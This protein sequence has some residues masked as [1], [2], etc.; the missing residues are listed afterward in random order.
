[1]KHY[2]IKNK[3]L[4]NRPIDIILDNFEEKINFSA[5][6]ANAAKCVPK[7]R[8]DAIGKLDSGFNFNINNLNKHI[9][10]LQM[11]IFCQT[12]INGHIHLFNKNVLFDFKDE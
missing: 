5:L 8:Y 2:L 4:I 3:T 11:D 7:S 12:I 1:M 6:I 9:I 10:V